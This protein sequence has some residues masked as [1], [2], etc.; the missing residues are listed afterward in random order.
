MVGAHDTIC[1]LQGQCCL[2]L[3]SSDARVGAHFGGYPASLHASLADRVCSQ[4]YPCSMSR[5]HQLHCSQRASSLQRLMQLSAEPTTCE[6]SSSTASSWIGCRC[7]P[8]ALIA[9]AG[10]AQCHRKATLVQC[11]K[12]RPGRGVALGSCQAFTAAACLDSQHSGAPVEAVGAI[13]EDT[14][15]VRRICRLRG[16]SWGVTE[17]AAGPCHTVPCSN[18]AAPLRA[19]LH[20]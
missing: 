13:G 3:H 18:V 20:K 10:H 2:M 16:C 17:E 7:L 6:A 14:A 19:S 15:G 9:A 8:W 4:P 1:G 12:P 5:G 11:L